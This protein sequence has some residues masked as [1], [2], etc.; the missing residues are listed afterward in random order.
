MKYPF[1]LVG[2]SVAL[3]MPCVV[4]AGTATV[5]SVQRPAGQ[6]GEPLS[7]RQSAPAVHQLPARL[8]ESE[9]TG[10][11]SARNP[12]SDVRDASDLSALQ[13]ARPLLILLQ[14]LRGPL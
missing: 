7:V 4:K 10:E 2:L 14:I 9:T 3:S 13:R 8:S 6:S 12:A 5:P 1:A 11:P